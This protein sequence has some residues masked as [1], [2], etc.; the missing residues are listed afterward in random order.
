MIP[1][2]S[3]L[4]R[5]TGVPGL[6]L[7]ALLAAACGG[8]DGTLTDQEYLRDRPDN[9]AHERRM[10]AVEWQ[11]GVVV[12]GAQDD[13]AL[14]SPSRISV[15]S[16][17]VYLLDYYPRT[18]RHYRHD[19]SLGWTFG[20]QGSGPDEFSDPRDLKVDTQGR[21]WV[22]DPANNRIMVLSPEGRV[23]WR[24][25]LAGVNGS[26]REFVPLAGGN[27]VIIADSREGPPL[28][29]LDSAGV[30]SRARPFPWSGFSRLEYLATQLVAAQNASTGDWA[31]GF[32]VGDGFFSYTREEQ[33]RRG[34]FVE[35]VAFPEVIVTK[36]GNTTSWRHKERP[37]DA[38]ISVT[39]SPERVYVLFGGTT[40]QRGR[41]VDSYSLRTGA[42]VDTYALPHGASEIAWHDGGLYTLANRPYP[43]L[44]YWHPRGAKLP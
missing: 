26:P 4:A 10:T 2:S 19:G 28:V 32:R 41:L 15:N 18:V 3:R 9:A 23:A 44:A 40:R 25:P 39:L 22:L 21:V 16:R 13:S 20:R 38:A 42:Y 33:G 6:A 27:S 31:M 5:R 37:V 29:H 11:R 34:W 7:A 35:H 36:S 43:E 1:P 14:V 12:G 17:G 30:V 24:T 8:A